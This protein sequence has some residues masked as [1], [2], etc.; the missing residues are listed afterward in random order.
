[1]ADGGTFDLVGC[2]GTSDCAT[3]A[4]AAG[5]FVS[6]TSLIEANSGQSFVADYIQTT[7]TMIGV[8]AS[9]I[10]GVVHQLDNDNFEFIGKC[11][12]SA[13]PDS[14]TPGAGCFWATGSGNTA[15]VNIWT[16]TNGKLKVF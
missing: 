1:M 7:M 6:E 5:G 4:A 10:D 2:T 16:H 3:T 13:G 11:P 12:S 15:I 9:Q 8:Q 14:T